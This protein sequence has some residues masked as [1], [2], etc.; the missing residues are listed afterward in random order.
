MALSPGLEI[1]MVD[2]QRERY[3]ML[4]AAAIIIDVCCCGK[5]D[6]DVC[7]CCW[8]RNEAPVGCRHVGLLWICRSMIVSIHTIALTF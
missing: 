5:R 3:Y 6:T 4:V 1:E 7:C 8:S 2:I